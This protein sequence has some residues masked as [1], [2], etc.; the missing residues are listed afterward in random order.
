M[1]YKDMPLDEF[2]ELLSVSIQLDPS[3]ITAAEM[4]RNRYGQNLEGLSVELTPGE[5]PKLFKYGKEE[6]TELG[7]AIYPIWV[8]IEGIAR[9]QIAREMY[10]S[11][12][13]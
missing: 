6:E 7:Y 12:K 3:T 2:V 4:I 11:I 10:R 1:D 8:Q 9:E 5:T 13:Q